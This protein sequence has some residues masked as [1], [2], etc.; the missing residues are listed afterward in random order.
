MIK[1]TGAE[2]K[3]YYNDPSA[4]PE[5]CWHEDEELTIDGAEYDDWDIDTIKDTAQIKLK[6]GVVYGEPSFPTG[7]SM[8]QHF[9][10][11]KKAQL[12][13]IIVISVPNEKE[14][15]LKD[16]VSSIGGKVL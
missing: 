12:N 5:G 11:W 15:E 10:V 14:N 6:Y 3:A 2:F 13:R 9:R 7:R 4:W 16:L 1:T 8:E